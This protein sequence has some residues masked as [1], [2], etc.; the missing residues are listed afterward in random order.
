[1]QLIPVIQLTALIHKCFKPPYVT[2]IVLLCVSLISEINAI[3]Y[4]VY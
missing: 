2:F 4:Y 1:M 3:H